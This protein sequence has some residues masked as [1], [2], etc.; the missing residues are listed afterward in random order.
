MYRTFTEMWECSTKNW[1]SGMNFS[2]SLALSSVASM[3]LGRW[4]PPLIALVAAIAIASGTDLSSLFIPAAL[5]WL[6]Q[7]LVMAISSKRS[8][9]SP[10][11]ALTSPLGL[12]VIYAMLLDSTIRITTG[13]G[14]TRESDAESTNVV[15]FGRRDFP[16]PRRKSQRTKR[17]QEDRRQFLLR[18]FPSII[19]ASRCLGSSTIATA[20]KVGPPK[21]YGPTP[22]ARQLRWHELEFYGFIHFTINTFTDKE[23]GY[24]MSLLHFSTLLTSMRSRSPVPAAAE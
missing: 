7:V 21:P 2:L 18:S 16:P 19:L 6:C 9:V 3:Y 11:Y 23:W 1:F 10:L 22:S 24:E 13:R 12:G 4:P 15:E 20:T 8:G 17:E 5:S 14:V